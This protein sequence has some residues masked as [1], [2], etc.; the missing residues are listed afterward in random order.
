MESH[1]SLCSCRGFG[2]VL[3]YGVGVEKWARIEESKMCCTEKGLDGRTEEGLMHVLHSVL[4]VC[5]G[6]DVVR[7]VWQCSR[8]CRCRCVGG[9]DG[10]SP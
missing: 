1:G 4:N 5:N 8:R 6:V 10:E 2:E 7:K 3:S 9:C